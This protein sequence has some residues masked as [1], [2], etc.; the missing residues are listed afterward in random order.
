MLE[1]SGNYKNYYHH[2]NVK[3]YKCQTKQFT[4]L[5]VSDKYMSGYKTS[6]KAN[7]A[8][9]PFE[10]W[11]KKATEFI[12]VPGDSFVSLSFHFVIEIIVASLAYD[13]NTRYHWLAYFHNCAHSSCYPNTGKSGLRDADN[14]KLVG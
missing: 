11:C 6:G 7:N 2:K 8:D 14:I 3:C 5:Q 1:V 13:R 12:F 10:Y 4:N 9:Q